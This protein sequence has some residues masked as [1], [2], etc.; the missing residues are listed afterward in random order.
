[1]FSKTKL[2]RYFMISAVLRLKNEAEW[3]D[4]CLKTIFPIFSEI[5]LVTQGEQTD[6]TVE[7]CR[8]WD[9]F[10]KVHYYHYEFDSRPNGPGH[11]RQPYDKLSRAFFYNWAFSKAT[12]DWVCKWDG[13]ML[14]LPP[15]K[16]YLDKAVENNKS[17]RFKG[18]DVVE[19]LYHI[20]HREFCSPEN[21]LY[22]TGNYVN[23]KYSETLRDRTPESSMEVDEPLFIHTKWA[24]SIDSATKAWPKN[25]ANSKHFNNIW[26]RRIPVKKHSYKIPEGWIK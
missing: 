16:N 11:G 14:A 1:M 21:R 7:I 18:V 10:D 12:N 6:N 17:L 15:C 26:E 8:K 19:D 4:L 23:G 24:K 2:R 5:V 13:D 25:W 22:K 9:M 20:G 3:L